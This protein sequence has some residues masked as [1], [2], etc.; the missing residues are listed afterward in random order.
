MLYLPDTLSAHIA[1]S[2]RMEWISISFISSRPIA[3]LDSPVRPIHAEAQQHSLIGSG[4]GPLFLDQACWHLLNTLPGT[5]VLLATRVVH[6]MRRAK[7]QHTNFKLP[8]LRIA[9]LT[10]HSQTI[11]RL[12][13]SRRDLATHSQVFKKN[14]PPLIEFIHLAVPQAQQ[15]LC[16]D[17][18]GDD[19]DKWVEQ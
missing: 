6:A 7:S 9:V 16:T 4:A 8:T 15:F 17:S 3:L 13:V 19:L 11:R 1:L 12:E 10:A 14:P 5:D 18:A 2:D